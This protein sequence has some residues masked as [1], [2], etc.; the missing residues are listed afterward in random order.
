VDLNSIL[1]LRGGEVRRLLAGRE[2]QVMDAVAR[3]YV[4]HGAGDSALPHS[5]FLRFPHDERA[6]IIALPAYVGGGLHVAGMKWIA[7]FPR[8]LDAGM[9]RASATIVLNSADTG[10]PG[11][12]LEASIIS[13]RRTAASAAL[14][15]AKMHAGLDATVAGIVG[16]GPISLEMVRFLRV[17]FPEMRS[18]VLHDLSRE[19]AEHFAAV[20]AVEVGDFDVTYAGSADEVLASAPLVAF[21]TTAGKPYVASL[22]ADGPRPQTILHVSLRDLAPEI[23]L[24]SD[25]VVDDAD[26][27]CRAATSLHLAEEMTGGRGFIRCSLADVLE[28]R[29]PA[30][31]DGGVAIFSPFGLGVL[32]MAV[33]QLVY[34]LAVDE[35]Q[36]TVFGGFLPEPW[37][38]ALATAEAEAVPA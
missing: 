12:I 29:A 17:A 22:P 24:A 20:L 4:A 38:A 34:E 31:R 11:A 37:D 23:I 15:A 3:A 36:G 10:R 8:N 26:H 13:A 1:L 19:R 9:E 35:G 32:D 18:L 33:A 27:V 14:A 2:R 28:G 6:R 21:G 7:S 5:T 16:C 30:R 25:N